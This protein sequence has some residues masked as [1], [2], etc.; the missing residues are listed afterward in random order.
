M[1]WLQKW[2][3]T[4]LQLTSKTESIDGKTISS[5]KC[6]LQTTQ[7]ARPPQSKLHNTFGQATLDRLNPGSGVKPVLVLPTHSKVIAWTMLKIITLLFSNTNPSPSLN[8]KVLC[9]CG[10][11]PYCCSHANGT[12][13]W[14]NGT[15]HKGIDAKNYIILNLEK[16]A[17]NPVHALQCIHIFWDPVSSV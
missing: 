2:K 12:R 9:P 11:L 7:S 1:H 17:N 5:P 10:E 16:S 13:I 6:Q 8:L 15:Q 4:N 3:P 14:A